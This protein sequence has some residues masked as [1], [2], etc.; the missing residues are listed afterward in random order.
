MREH[1]E[2]RS[3]SAS[4]SGYDPTEPEYTG[5]V[6][7]AYRCAVNA[8][9]VWD[10]TPRFDGAGDGAADFRKVT[11]FDA[12]FWCRG[13]TIDRLGDGTSEYDTTALAGYRCGPMQADEPVGGTL[14]RQKLA[15]PVDDARAAA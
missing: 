10:A 6:L 1:R 9:A 7:T 4:W 8:D 3:A 14:R 5:T 15:T 13:S 12:H 11:S 2:L